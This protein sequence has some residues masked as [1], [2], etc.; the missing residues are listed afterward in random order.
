MATLKEQI[1][2]DLHDAMRAH[3]EIRKSALRMLT[4]ATRNAEIDARH[5][6]DDAAVLTV[7][8]KQ[9][10]QRRESIVEFRKGNRQDLVDKERAE[11]TVLGVLQ[12]QVL[13]FAFTVDGIHF[14]HTREP[15]DAVLDVHHI[16]S[17]LHID[18]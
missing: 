16:F 1:Q 6:F 15:A 18:K 4:A 9:A 13:F 17:R 3:D 5:D 10:K 11:I 8:Q 12:H 2:S 14:F 7:L